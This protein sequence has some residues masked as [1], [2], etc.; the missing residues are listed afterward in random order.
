MVVDELIDLPPNCVARVPHC[1]PVIQAG[2]LQFGRAFNLPG[3]S[4]NGTGKNGAGSLLLAVTERDD[5]VKTLTEIRIDYFRA[6]A[7]NID[8]N[9]P[10]RSH[11]VWVQVA[12]LGSRTDDLQ[13]LAGQLPKKS[14]GHLSTAGVLRTKKQHPRLDRHALPFYLQI[15]VIF[16]GLMALLRVQHSV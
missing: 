14:L 13:F 3:L 8:S 6:G 16:A 9:L 5:V 2:G 15:C 10:H 12:R 1:R 4:P 7:G 11:R